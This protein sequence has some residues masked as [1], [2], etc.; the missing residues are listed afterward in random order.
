MRIVFF[1]T[2]LSIVIS[3]TN[4][5]ENDI[6]QQPP[7]AE[8]TDSIQQF[9]QNS[10]LYY[11]RGVM[12]YQQEQRELAKKDL[13]YAWQLAPQEDYALSLTTIL[14]QQHTDSA[15][16][17]LQ[18]AT[19]TLPTSIA[20]QIGLARGYQ[21]KNEYDKALEIC[22][23]IIKQFPNQLD[24]LVLKSEILQQQN[25]NYEAIATLEKAYSFAPF[26]IDI[27]HELAYAY[28][29]AKNKKVLALTDTLIKYDQSEKAAIAWYIKGLY[30]DNTGAK[31][32]AIKNYDQAIRQNYT[33]LDPY[34]AKGQALYDL[35]KWDEAIATFQLG[36]KVSPT[37]A[38][39]F[40]W[41]GKTQEATGKK[42][43]AKQNYERA[44]QLDKTMTEAREA[45]QKL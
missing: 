20:L 45:A 22:N 25:K 34:L 15:I 44:Y 6:L 21:Q 18:K 35:K 36:Q 43:E 11:K 24:A 16:L 13:Q 19:Q 42:Q 9:P 30:F 23:N 41:I 37:T 31:Q 12:L 32:E 29:E 2:L 3:C 17:F 40:Y 10:A 14:K 7:Y 26:D 33:L 38:D 8:L 1:I 39:F 28:A 4:E 5:K 27:A